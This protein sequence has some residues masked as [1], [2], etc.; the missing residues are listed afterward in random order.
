MHIREYL[1]KTNKTII[2]FAG[3][4]ITLLTGEFDYIT[5]VEISFGLF[6]LLPI[7][8]VTWFVDKKG[9]MLIAFLSMV[10]WLLA[11][12]ASVE[13][14]SSNAIP[15]W[16]AIVRFGFFAIVVY[17]LSKVKNLSLRLEENVKARTADLTS[18]ITERK[19]TEQ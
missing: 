11:D 8:F 16:N 15:F 6:Y 3:I 19:K 9:G 1:E 5:G 12:M 17:L 2:F 7:V 18:E 14:Y 4:F 10:L 13:R